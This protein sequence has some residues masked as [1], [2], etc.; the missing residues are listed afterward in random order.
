MESLIL[1]NFKE[2]IIQEYNICPKIKLSELKKKILSGRGAIYEEAWLFENYVEKLNQEG[3][4]NI[5]VYPNLIIKTIENISY[6]DFDSK[7]NNQYDFF[8]KIKSDEHQLI[9][10]FYS[11]LLNE[12]KTLDWNKVTG[13]FR[14]IHSLKQLEIDISTN[15]LNEIITNFIDYIT[16]YSVDKF[17]KLLEYF[18]ENESKKIHYKNLPSLIS[19][20]LVNYYNNSGF[21]FYNNYSKMFDFKFIINYKDH[22]ISTLDHITYSNMEIIRKCMPLIR[23]APISKQQIFSHFETISIYEIEICLTELRQSD[24]FISYTPLNMLKIDLT[25]IHIWNLSD[26]IILNFF[27][28]YINNTAG[29]EGLEKTHYTIEEI[30]DRLFDIIKNEEEIVQ[31]LLDLEKNSQILIKYNDHEIIFEHNIFKKSWRNFGRLLPLLRPLPENYLNS[32]TRQRSEYIIGLLISSINILGND[33]VQGD[34]IRIPFISYEN[35]EHFKGLF[36]QYNLDFE[37]LE[38]WYILIFHFTDFGKCLSIALE[39]SDIYEINKISVLNEMG[40]MIQDE[41]LEFYKNDK[42]L[43]DL[44]ELLKDRTYRNDMIK[45]FL[46][47]LRNFT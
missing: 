23:G 4:T 47:L 10:K 2:K 22:E 41:V 43:D 17:G 33:F 27:P 29:F 3:F 31:T 5:R 42:K 30:L 8:D 14:L 21:L 11:R 12:N 45:F 26:S 44:R 34:K 40:F 24:D 36:P 35:A 28:L 6:L 1:N 32:S 19:Y 37:I 9:P 15:I 38:N 16:F 46:A 18:S 20:A 25:K 7:F 13:V 39:S